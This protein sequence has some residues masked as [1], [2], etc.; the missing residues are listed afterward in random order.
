LPFVKYDNVV[1]DEL[2]REK[3]GRVVIGRQWAYLGLF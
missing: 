3:S 1:H 2:I